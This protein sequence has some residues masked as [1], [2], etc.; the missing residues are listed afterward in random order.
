MV[1]TKEIILGYAAEGMSALVDVAMKQ[2][3]VVLEEVAGI[4]SVK[5]TDSAV[6]MIF[7]DTAAVKAASAAWPKSNFIIITYSPDG[8][9]NTADERGFYTVSAIS[10]D[11]ASFTAT[12]SG[13][14]SALDEQSEDAVVEFDTITAPAKRDLQTSFSG[15]INGTL[16]DTGNLKIVVDQA[17]FESNIRIKGGFRFNFLKFKSSKMYL[18]ID[19]SGLVNLNVSTTVAASFSSDMYKYQPLSASVSAFSIPGILDVGPIAK[20]GLGVEFAASG[21]VDAS[22][23]LHSEIVN[24]QVHLDLLDSNKTSSSGW[25][26]ETSV[27]SDV[28]AEVSLQLNPYLDLNLALGIRVFKGVIDLTTG[29]EVKPQIINAFSADL[30]FAYASSSGITFTKPD[31]ATC[32]NGAWFAS[33]FNMDVNAYIGTVYTKTLYSVNAPIFQPQCWSFAG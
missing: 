10:F 21:T 13:Q 12:A 1:P 15:E 25:K 20:F 27:S 7:S 17:K 18:D 9:C 3:T 11:E 8:G 24:G 19:Y 14:R 28:S 29:V 33:T 4:T 5:C 2:P 23:G 31:T 26:P 6:S 22:L 32:P 30:N 16:I